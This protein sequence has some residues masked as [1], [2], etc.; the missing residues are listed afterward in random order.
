MSACE[1]KQLRKW[2]RGPSILQRCVYPPLPISKL[3]LI[4][5]ETGVT[6]RPEEIGQAYQFG[7]EATIPNVLERNWWET[8]GF[9]E[10]QSAIAA[11]ALRLDMERRRREDEGEEVDMEELQKDAKAAVKKEMGI[12]ASQRNG[13]DAAVADRVIARTRVSDS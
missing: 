4:K 9:A 1:V 13:K 3:L 6:L 11:E 7:H 8:N 12:G 10:E 5:Q 2:S